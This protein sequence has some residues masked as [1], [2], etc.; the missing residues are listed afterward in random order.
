[1]FSSGGATVSPPFRLNLPL[2][3]P[4]REKGPKESRATKTAGNAIKEK[5]VHERIKP[6]RQRKG[7][8]RPRAY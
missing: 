7:R 8:E 1:M 4:T 6:G 5:E 3:P 2:T